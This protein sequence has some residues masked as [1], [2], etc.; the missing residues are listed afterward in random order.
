MNLQLT[1]ALLL[2]LNLLLF[3]TTRRMRSERSKV[4]LQPLHGYSRLGG[5]V[6]QAV[7][8]GQKLHISLGQGSI[9]GPTTATSVA[10]AQFLVKLAKDS[11][12]NN[13]PPVVTVGDATILPLAENYIRNAYDN[14]G[15]LYQYKP[16]HAQ[17]LAQADDNFVFAAGVTNELLQNKVLTH[18]LAG[19]YGAEIGIITGAAV[20]ENVD[21]IIAT[22]NLTALAIGTAVSDDLIVGEELFVAGAYLENKVGQLASL[23]VQDTL[24]WLIAI[25]LPLIALYHLVIG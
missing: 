13:T 20:R 11:C 25:S 2:L 23:R 7:E 1:L 8:S 21:Q 16:E 24:R 18:V 12:A 5:E 9:V 15:R 6:G 17:F 22:D 4:R 14:A 3:M 19:R 10:A